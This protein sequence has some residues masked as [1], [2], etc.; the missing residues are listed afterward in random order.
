MFSSA[1]QFAVQRTAPR[2]A[3]ALALCLGLA[4]CDKMKAMFG[5]GGGPADV[6][7]AEIDVS[8]TPCSDNGKFSTLILKDGKYTLGTYQFELFGETK[9][10]DVYG[11][12]KKDPPEASVFVGDC[13]IDG[14]TS[15]VLFVYGNDDSG[16]FH[17]LG[18]ANLTDNGNGNGNGLVQSYDVSGSTIHVE[19]NQ[20]NPPRLSKSIY[21][22]LNGKLTNV[23]PGAS[24]TAGGTNADVDTV[25]FQVF[26]DKLTGSHRRPRNPGPRPVIDT[27]SI[28]GS[29]Y[30]PGGPRP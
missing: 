27:S 23:T 1:G 12:T 30:R 17:R 2:V 16:K 7:N 19:Q 26:H 21:A 24:T 15:Q 4:G 20:G 22:L 18:D 25:E 9:H 29:Q 3:A 10:G 28:G 11:R 5:T 14:Q 13:A 8:G 6:R